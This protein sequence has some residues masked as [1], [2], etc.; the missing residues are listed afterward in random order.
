MEAV[1]RYG[2]VRL[3]I[4]HFGLIIR[5]SSNRQRESTKGS[6]WVVNVREK[7]TLE[8]DPRIRWFQV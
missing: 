5:Y 1:N 4:C 3:D 7:N 2:L 8:I 6:T